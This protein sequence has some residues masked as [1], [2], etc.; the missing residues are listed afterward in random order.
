[1]NLSSVGCALVFLT[2]AVNGLMVNGVTT[3]VLIT[4]IDEG[5]APESV[6]TRL[7]DGIHT[8]TDEVGLTYVEGRNHH[9]HF[10]NGIEGNGVTTAGKTIGK[11]EVVVEVST[12]D[13]EV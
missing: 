10:L 13:R 9:L 1:M 11:T 3:E 7:R 6:G 8:T 2:G 4:M 12:I 5:T